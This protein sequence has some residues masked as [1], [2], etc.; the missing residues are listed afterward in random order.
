[1]TEMLTG[2]DLNEAMTL[3]QVITRFTRRDMMER[4]ESKEELDQIQLMT[5]HASK[6][7]EFPYVFL[8]RMKEGLLPHQNSI[9]DNNIEEER[10]LAYVGITRAQK[11]LTFTCA[12]SGVNTVHWSSQRRAAACLSCHRTMCNSSRYANRLPPRS[13]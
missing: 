7:L 2:F 4:G 6:K 8:V 10:G 11:E 5:L 3:D 12:A 1:M 9:D 13:A